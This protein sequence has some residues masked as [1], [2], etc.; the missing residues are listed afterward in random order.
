ML[1]SEKYLIPIEICKGNPG[2]NSVLVDLYKLHTKDDFDH[3][4][5]LMREKKIEG[6]RVWGAY[7]YISNKDMDS[8]VVFLKNYQLDQDICEYVNPIEISLD[9]FRHHWEYY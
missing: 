7:K 8:F 2:C 1:A 4:V 3:F 9:A 6:G 5:T